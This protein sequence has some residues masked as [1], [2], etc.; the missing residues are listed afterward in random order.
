MNFHIK[1]DMNLFFFKKQLCYCRIFT[2]EFVE[3]H[4][5]IHDYCVVVKL[6][7]I[8]ETTNFKK[9]YIL[10]CDRSDEIKLIKNF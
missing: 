7:T 4:V 8:D 2:L 5:K 6:T 10:M 1:N 3:N 9:H